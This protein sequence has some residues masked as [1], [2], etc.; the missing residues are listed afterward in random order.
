[1][2]Q[3]FIKVILFMSI[4]C[5]IIQLEGKIQTKAKELPTIQL[6]TQAETVTNIPHK[7]SDD[8]TTI[9]VDDKIVLYIIIGTVSVICIALLIVIVCLVKK[10]KKPDVKIDNIESH[11]LDVGEIVKKEEKVNNVQVVKNAS[12]DV[13]FTTMLWQIAIQ[14]IDK[15]TDVMYQITFDSFEVNKNIVIGRGEKKKVDI[16]IPKPNI[17]GQHCMIIKEGNKYYISDLNSTNGTRYN[18]IKVNEKVK[19]T[20]TGLL[21]L[22]KSRFELI[23][24]DKQQMR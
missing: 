7:N 10:R 9:T 8:K 16:A 5:G 14:V 23:I 12:S 20:Q 18:G 13:S 3:K 17:S 2:K 11:R 24:K 4:L 22:G 15:S 19:I 1:M 21:E 6:E